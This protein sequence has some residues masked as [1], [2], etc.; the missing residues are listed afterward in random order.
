MK[1]QR[2]EGLE[3]PGLVLQLAQADQV[4]DAMPRLFDVAVKHRRIRL[5]SQLVGFAVDAE[6]GFGVGLVLANLVA[7]VGVE[8]FRAAAGQ[9]A[10][11]SFFELGENLLG[12]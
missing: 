5:E 9:A 10:Q 1:S 3:P 8:Y 6:P 7:D 11:A 4:V 2:N 12:G